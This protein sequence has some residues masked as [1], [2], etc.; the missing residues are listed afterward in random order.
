LK[1]EYQFVEAKAS[2]PYFRSAFAALFADAIG[3]NRSS[4]CYAERVEYQKPFPKEQ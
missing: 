2:I 3:I 4:K 1:S